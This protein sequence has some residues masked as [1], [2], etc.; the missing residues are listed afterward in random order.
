MGEEVRDIIMS[1]IR[2]DVMGN[3]LSKGIRFDGRGFSDMRPVTIQ[4]RRDNDR[5]S[6]PPSRR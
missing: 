6:D 1:H 3:T 2:R 5:G 4:A